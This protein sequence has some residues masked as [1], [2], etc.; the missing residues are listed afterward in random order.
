MATAIHDEMFSPEVTADPYSYF[1]RLRDE[2]PVHWNSRYEVWV[3]TGYD[4]VTHITRHP[5]LFS[6]AFWKNDPRGAFPP[7]RPGDEDH[8]HF[9][10]D[11]ISK[12]V[13]QLDPP[14]HTRIRKAVY[15][16]FTPD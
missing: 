7:I 5:E 14:D 2:D 9:V 4:D 1:G 6:S 8:Y 15:P 11:V 10:T 12:W 13:V 16:Y 3:V